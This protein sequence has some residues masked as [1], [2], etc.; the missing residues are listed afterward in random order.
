MNEKIAALRMEDNDYVVEFETYYVP[1]SAEQVLINEGLR[2][3]DDRIDACQ[4]Q[5]NQFNKEIERLTNH[6]DGVDN[7]I[8][9]ASGILTGFMD[10]IL[11]GTWDFGLSKAHASEQINRSVIDFAKKQTGFKEYFDKHR[12]TN[13]DLECAIN[14]LEKTFHLPG[15]G[16]YSQFMSDGITHKTHHLDDFCHHPTI[17]GLISC[18]VV[19]FSGFAE[20]HGVKGSTAPVPVF[21]NEYGNFVSEEIWGK[22][23]AGIINWFFKAGKTLANRKGHLMSDIAGSAKTV[24]GGAGLPGPIMS[25]LK[26]VSS[27][28]IFQNEGFAEDL[29]KAYQNGIGTGN[30]QV[31]LGPFNSL[32]SGA[33]SK[34]DLRTEMAVGNLLKKQASVVV[35]NEVIVRATYFVKHFVAELKEKRSLL[36]IDWT[37]VLPFR[38]RT[39]TRMMTISLGAFEAVDM[40][41]AAIH[42]A[43]KS[44]GTAIGFFTEFVLHVNFVGVGRFA[45]AVSTDASM[46]IARSKERS[47]RIAAINEK[48]QL[49]DAKVFYNHANMW[50]A[51]NEAKKAFDEA[52]VSREEAKNA[53]I[54]SL[55]TVQE[56]I[57]EISRNVSDVDTK[58]PE[59]I[60]DLLKVFAEE[61]I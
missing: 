49:L 25:L 20:Y 14:F 57:D 59:L 28:K 1:A 56:D 44:G 6:A 2:D 45:M 34:V 27:L 46:G 5:I 9:V 50:I 10:I 53:V 41:D 40:T 38:N 31:D 33:S 60:N 16:N 23:F 17:V 54:E 3:V 35:L 52:D 7:M 19:Q 26:E 42:G 37:N 36:K 47:R 29:R 18:I 32:F 12:T 55:I 13:N 21:V 4:I 48:I 11:V 51:A 8:A 24:G 61:G 22:F 43:V 58:N 30:K 15:D 39:I